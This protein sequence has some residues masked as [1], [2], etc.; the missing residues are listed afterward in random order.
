MLKGPIKCHNP[1]WADR[2]AT[3]MLT[4]DDKQWILEQL[5]H[6]ETKLLTEFHRWASPT[7]MRVRS[8]SAVLRMLD[9]ELES[10]GERVTKLEER[11]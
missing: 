5:E 2:K 11:G 4:D 8:H 3:I 7:E 9:I 10:L 6:V 1:L